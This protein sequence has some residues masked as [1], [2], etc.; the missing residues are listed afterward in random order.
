VN[1]KKPVE[2]TP[3]YLQFSVKQSRE[4]PVVELSQDGGIKALRAGDALLGVTFG[5]ITREICIQVRAHMW[6]AEGSRC[7]QLRSPRPSAPLNTVWTINPDGLRSSISSPEFVVSRLSIEPPN[8]PVELAHPI[9][10]P[11]TISGGKIRQI[12]F[13]QKR[14]GSTPT[15]SSNAVVPAS[16]EGL[17]NADLK[18]GHF[19]EGP[20]GSKIFELIPVELGEET[21]RIV[22]QFE[23][24]GFDERFVHLQAEPTERDLDRINVEYFDWPPG[25]PHLKV[26]LKYRQ[27]SNDV[28]VYGIDRV[29]FSVTPPN[30][31]RFDSDGTA[32]ELQNGTAMVSVQLG[33]IR[34]SKAVHVDL[35][36]SSSGNLAVVTG[37]A[38]SDDG[39]EGYPLIRITGLSDTQ[40]VDFGP[41]LAASKRIM[42]AKWV[43]IAGA[44]RY[45]PGEVTIR[46]R[47]LPSGYLVNGGIFLDGRSGSTPLD[48]AAWGAVTSS[49]FKPL[50][51]E[52]HGSLEL[53]AVFSSN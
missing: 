5:K 49:R 18:D 15:I 45:P 20:G 39:Q 8:H 6:A 11:V 21:V 26:G 31:V 50:P 23:D 47:I 51:R 27:I 9:R 44:L 36:K 24:G 14:A 16:K 35:S 28:N 32:H 38:A 12:S 17:T 22:A 1:A 7:E 46:F 41:Y 2:I 25:H 30:I 4:E 37:E 33:A 52:F 53:R 42:K 48:R 29:K 3:D 13:E 34:G 40:G 19:L 43:Q 10:I